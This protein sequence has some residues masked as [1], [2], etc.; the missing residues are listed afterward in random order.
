M[1]NNPSLTDP[2]LIAVERILS[3]ISSASYFSNPTFLPLIICQQTKIA[4]KIGHSTYS[5]YSYVSFALMLSGVFSDIEGAYE[6]ALTAEKVMAKYP[7]KKLEGRINFVTN[8]CAYHWKTP[9]YQCVKNFR[10]GYQKS[11]EVGDYEYAGLNAGGVIGHSF[12]AGRSLAEIIKLFIGYEKA[13]RVEYK[14]IARYYGMYASA[15]PLIHL[16]QTEKEFKMFDGTPYSQNLLEK[17]YIEKKDLTSLGIIN[18]TKIVVNYLMGEYEKVLEHYDQLIEQKNSLAGSAVFTIG[19]Y[20]YGISLL[21]LAQ[22]QP[23]KKDF[24][25]RKFKK[26]EKKLRF[27]YQHGEINYAHK[28]ALL[29]A[30]KYALLKNYQKAALHYGEAI[31]KAKQIG[32]MHDEAKAYESAALFYEKY[33]QKDLHLFYLQNAYNTYQKWGASLKTQQLIKKYPEHIKQ[34]KYETPIY[35]TFKTISSTI[36]T[37]DLPRTSSSSKNFKSFDA[38]SLIK[39]LQVL[40][41][42]ILMQNLLEKMMQFVVENA[43]A[44]RG[45][46]ILD[47]NNK[48]L[49]QGEIDFNSQKKIFLQATPI[50]QY[51]QIPANIL[52]YVIRSQEYV[53][54]ADATLDERL[55]QNE[56]IQNYK[57]QSLLFVPLVKQGKLKGL[58]YLENNLTTGAFTSD[59][60]EILKLMSAQIAISIENAALYEN[61]EDK[62]KERTTEVMHQ[63]ELIEK[64]KIDI[65]EKSYNITA[66]INYA[67]R[68]QRAILP[69]PEAIRQSFQEHFIFYAPRDI[70]SGD[71]YWLH[72]KENKTLF[73]VI[74]CTGHGVPG[75]FMTV[76][77]N[78][79]M[80]RIVQDLQIETPHEILNELH[81]SIR[82]ILKQD[83]NQNRDG[84]DMSLIMIENNTLY[85]SAARNPLILIQ[86]GEMQ[87]VKGDKMSIGGEQREQQRS[88]TLHSFPLKPK[89]QNT[90]Y[91]FSDGY[92]DQIGGSETRKF[93]SRNLHQLL[94]SIHQ[95]SID[96]QHEIVANTIEQW[97]KQSQQE[98][99]DDI[100]VMGIRI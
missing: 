69:T 52:N 2:K 48:M 61:L 87:I 49:V 9:H 77:A 78:S 5:A 29:E 80:N 50:E 44:Q 36:T 68:I 22:E 28:Y 63:K 14:D 79:Q 11:V 97:M 91:L 40:S 56:Y 39:S 17:H 7:N 41:G 83:E 70:V 24:Y 60:V 58:L 6:L 74:D 47:D 15:A 92:Q 19:Q 88:F 43:G 10:E 46:L 20:Y 95:K 8:I 73:A 94:F 33:Q 59:R 53:V 38:L 25:L 93:L 89:G 98:Q 81:L 26:E 30:E 45:V 31:D 64:Q 51:Q 23:D 37:S 96:E 82:K 67:R 72:Q 3:N 65:E 55:T 27:Y 12:Y 90:I 84:M 21:K 66:S 1:L 71:F 75:A 34:E 62:V 86:E 100:L 42:E 35:E 32:C 13:F 16:T 57:P 4:A 76:I 54:I 99:L 18:Q 85:F